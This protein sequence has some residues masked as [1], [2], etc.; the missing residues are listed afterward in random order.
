[1]NFHI[2]PKNLEVN[3]NFSIIRLL[4]LKKETRAAVKIQAQ[5][6]SYKTRREFIKIKA[7]LVKLQV[8]C[9]PFFFNLLLVSQI[10]IY[11]KLNLKKGTVSRLYREKKPRAHSL[12]HEGG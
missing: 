6:R 7:N 11:I 4:K 8:N 10:L 12:Q 3:Y 1:L 2:F 5:W 9:L